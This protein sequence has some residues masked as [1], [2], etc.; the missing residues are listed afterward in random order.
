MSDVPSNLIPTRITQLPLAPE[1][2]KNVAS[3]TT[4]LVAILLVEVVATCSFAD[5]FNCVQV[6]TSFE[7][8]IVTFC[9]VGT[10]NGP[11]APAT[12]SVRVGALAEPGGTAI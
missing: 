11:L 1:A 7:L 10:T 6:N 4:T 12:V 8:L 9:S 3:S 2:P 5:S